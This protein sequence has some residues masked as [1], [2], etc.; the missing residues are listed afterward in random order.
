MLSLELTAEVELIIRAARQAEDIGCASRQQRIGCVVARRAVV[1]L[2]GV[3]VGI[4]PVGVLIVVVPKEGVAHRLGRTRCRR[5]E[6]VG[7]GHKGRALFLDC[8]KLAQPILMADLRAGSVLAGLTA[9]V[10]V[11]D[12]TL[13]VGGHKLGGER[14]ADALPS[15]VEVNIFLE[16]GPALIPHQVAGIEG[17]SH[18]RIEVLLVH[19]QMIVGGGQVALYQ[20][21]VNKIDVLAHQS[22]AAGIAVVRFIYGIDEVCGQHTVG[23]TVDIAVACCRRSINQEVLRLVTVT[24]ACQTVVVEQRRVEPATVQAQLVGARCMAFL[25]T[26]KVDGG[27]AGIS[28]F[29]A[30]NRV[31]CQIGCGIEVGYTH[32][33][34]AEVCRCAIYTVGIVELRQ[35][36]LIACNCC[37]HILMRL[38]SPAVGQLLSE[39]DVVIG[40]DGE[41]AALYLFLRRSFINLPSIVAFILRFRYLTSRVAEVAVGKAILN[42]HD[43]VRI[44]LIARRAEVR[45]VTVVMVVLQHQLIIV[46]DGEVAVLLLLRA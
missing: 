42:V 14:Q 36:A 13:R 30:V 19:E 46:T 9:A 17:V 10:E 28:L 11:R 5:I 12:L 8:P 15:A 41:E 22:V 45:M 21:A 34:G 43:D 18:R 25:M 7:L 37:R 16:A 44:V 33:L 4:L 38:G 27:Q 35:T 2:I 1:L 26:V 6:E 20:V 39:E 24:D 23:L 31:L 40:P 32:I 3:V 29:R